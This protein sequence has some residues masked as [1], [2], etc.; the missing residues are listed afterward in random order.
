MLCNNFFVAI[1]AAVKHIKKIYVMTKTQENE[2][3]KKRIRERNAKYQEFQN[4]LL[5]R[6]KLTK[7]DLL[8]NWLKV[9]VN[10]NLDLLTP[11]E[12]KQYETLVPV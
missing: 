8:D 5:K 12:M 11:V 9:W 10:D 3:R 6:A 7:K 2:M 1:F 4:L